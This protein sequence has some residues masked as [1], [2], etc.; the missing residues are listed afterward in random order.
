MV[1]NYAESGR[2][3]NRPAQV[4]VR[5]H[6]HR[7]SEWRHYGSRGLQITAITPSWQ[8]KTGYVYKGQAKMSQPQLGGILIRV[9]DEELHTRAMVWAMGRS[10]TEVY[11]AK[12]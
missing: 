1:E 2:W 9:G 12:G 11:G 6:R 3:G 10:K 8:L 4:I 5:S 7:Y